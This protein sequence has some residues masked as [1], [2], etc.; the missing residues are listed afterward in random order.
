MYT[1]VI[2]CIT[3][4]NTIAYFFFIRFSIFVFGRV[5]QVK[6]IRWPY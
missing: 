4:V 3:I 6:R 5:G 2:Q 1:N